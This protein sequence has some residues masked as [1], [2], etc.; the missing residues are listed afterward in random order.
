MTSRR[1]R[2]ACE[3]NRTNFVGAALGGPNT[4][5]TALM[6][7]VYERERIA[8]LN[9]DSKDRLESAVSVEPLNGKTW[10]S[11]PIDLT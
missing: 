4:G 8:A 7:L 2:E 6:M 9:G 10:S 1:L 3:G 5:T 11:R